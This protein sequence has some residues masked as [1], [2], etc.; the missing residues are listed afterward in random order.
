MSIQREKIDT[1]FG[2][3]PKLALQPKDC[4]QIICK[5]VRIAPDYIYGI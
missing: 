1:G 2:K 4:N 3:V 5:D